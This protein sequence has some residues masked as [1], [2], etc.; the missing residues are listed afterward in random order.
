M[1]RRDGAAIRTERIQEIAKIVHSLLA[2]SED[3]WIP[4]SRTLRLLEYKIG[5]TP[6]KLMEYLEVPADL[7]Q[8]TIDQEHD[9]IKKFK[10]DP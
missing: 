10:A 6:R 2:S 3:G 5:L 9:K 7:E 4:L 1:G 8:F